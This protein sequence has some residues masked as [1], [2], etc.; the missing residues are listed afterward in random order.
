[1]QIHANICIMY[2]VICTTMQIICCKCAIICMLQDL[3]HTSVYIVCSFMC[4]YVHLLICNYMHL[5]HQCISVHIYAALAYILLCEYNPY[6]CICTAHFAH[7]R[8][9]IVT[10]PTLTCTAAEPR[11]ALLQ[12]IATIPI[13]ERF[14]VYCSQ[15]LIVF[16]LG[17]R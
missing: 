9:L 8:E 11:R 5:Y 4:N 14:V 12:F 6:F 7:G 2:P 15:E 10:S 1:M 17:R 16:K 13:L 3:I